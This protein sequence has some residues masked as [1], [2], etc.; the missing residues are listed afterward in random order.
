MLKKNKD[1]YNYLAILDPKSLSF[2]TMELSCK[3]EYVTSNFV[4]SFNNWVEELRFMPPVKLLDELRGKLMEAI[5][6]RKTTAD[7]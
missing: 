5:W 1:A 6:F 4:K 2:Y 3:V 7:K